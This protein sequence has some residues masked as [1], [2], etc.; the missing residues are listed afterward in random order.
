MKSKLVAKTRIGTSTSPSDSSAGSTF[1]AKYRPKEA[2]R[3]SVE[4]TSASP[5]SLATTA[6]SATLDSGA[7]ANSQP[8]LVTPST[9][10]APG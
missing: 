10:A 9:G 1:A 7:S 8:T 5:S 2:V 3:I 4:S 6:G